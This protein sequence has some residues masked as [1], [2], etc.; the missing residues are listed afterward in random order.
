MTKTA[1]LSIIILFVVMIA[2]VVSFSQEEEATVEEP[3]DSPETS[4]PEK[5]AAGKNF[6]YIAA[7]KTVYGEK[8]ESE[9][10]DIG[11]RGQLSKRIF[12]MANFDIALSDTESEMDT[13][14][15]P[16]SSSKEFS[17]AGLSIDYVV[18]K[19]PDL[20]RDLFVGYKMKLFDGVPYWGFH[21]GSADVCNSKFKGSYVTT[22]YLQRLYKI[23]SL[24]NAA[25][26]RNEH[27][28]NLFI[29][30]YLMSEGANIPV[31]N[32]LRIRAG[33]LIPTPFWNNNPEPVADD[34]KTRI[35]IEVPIGELVEH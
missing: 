27:N 10:F 5:T 32:C 17:D 31:I 28:H 21:I 23:D 8:P 9:F 35:V 6:F 1:K 7:I 20:N 29:E 14:A 3:L 26:D 30:I 12:T 25:S 16:G 34:I 33:I 13:T 15:Q 11:M 18:F 22:G 2:P 4:T 19:T 24:D